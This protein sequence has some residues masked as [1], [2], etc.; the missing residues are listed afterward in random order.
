MVQ[1][2]RID[3]VSHAPASAGPSEIRVPDENFA[4]LANLNAP[5]RARVLADR[6]CSSLIGAPAKCRPSASRVEF[7]RRYETAVH[8]SHFIYTGSTFKEVIVFTR[9]ILCP[10]LFL[11]TLYACG[12]MLTW[13]SLGL[14]LMDTIIPFSWPASLASAANSALTSSIIIRNV[15]SIHRVLIEIVLMVILGGIERTKWL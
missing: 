4:P 15:A 13:F 6:L 14:R 12:P 7:I 5:L 8:R 2:Y 11:T 10:R 9:K 1:S 3:A